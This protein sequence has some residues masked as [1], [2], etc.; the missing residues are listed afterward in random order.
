MINDFEHGLLENAV[1]DMGCRVL[2]IDT[3]DTSMYRLICNDVAAAYEQMKS[4]WDDERKSNDALLKMLAKARNERD[5]ALHAL[6]ECWES[7]GL[8]LQRHSATLTAARKYVTDLRER[9]R[10]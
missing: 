10:I 1:W 8:D 7:E 4:A 2:P 9:G 5:A 6:Y 3:Y